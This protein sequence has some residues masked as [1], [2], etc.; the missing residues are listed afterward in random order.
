MWLIWAPECWA[1]PKGPLSPI[2]LSVA[3]AHWPSISLRRIP[4]LGRGVGNKNLSQ[5]QP[6]SE[7]SGGC[8]AGG[9]SEGISR[10]IP[11]RCHKEPPSCATSPFQRLKRRGCPLGEGGEA[12][13]WWVGP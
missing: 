7:E 12:G 10:P 2:W 13:L 4:G 11:Q 5:S 1:D 8:V 6:S 3:A 9:L